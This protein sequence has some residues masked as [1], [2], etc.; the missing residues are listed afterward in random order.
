MA[1]MFAGAASQADAEE[2]RT[3]L[4]QIISAETGEAQFVAEDL[5]YDPATATATVTGRGVVTTPWQ[6]ENRRYRMNV[7]RV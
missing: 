5:R 6:R 2:R 3:T 4:Q 1:E 7:D